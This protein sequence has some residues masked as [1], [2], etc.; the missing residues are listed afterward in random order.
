LEPGI[1]REVGKELDFLLE[2]DLR[3]WRSPHAGTISVEQPV[4]TI[5]MNQDDCFSVMGGIGSRTPRATRP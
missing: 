3:G 4:A 2:G 1:E 5:A